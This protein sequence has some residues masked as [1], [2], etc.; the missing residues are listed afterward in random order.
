MSDSKFVGK[1]SALIGGLIMLF[2]H[3][4]QYTRFEGTNDGSVILWGFLLMW[5]RSE[6]LG[7]TN[8]DYDTFERDWIDDDG[9]YEGLFGNAMFGIIIVVLIIA[10]IVFTFVQND[11]QI[12]AF[13]LIGAAVLLLILRFQELN[14]LNLSFYKSEN[15]FTFIEIPLGFIAGDRKSVV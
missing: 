14:D 6:L 1:I 11:S 8:S 3:T 10:A 9:L 15:S 13:L 5:F 4:I 12:N 7:Q 2:A